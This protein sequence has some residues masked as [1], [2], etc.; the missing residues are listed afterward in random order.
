MKL[1]YSTHPFGEDLRFRLLT[2]EWVYLTACKHIGENKVFEYL[3][4]LG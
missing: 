4:S 3:Y 2:V 1:S